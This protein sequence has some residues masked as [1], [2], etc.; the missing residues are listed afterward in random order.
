MLCNATGQNFIQIFR[1]F[2]ITTLRMAHM[3]LLELGPYTS[4]F[5]EELSTSH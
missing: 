5:S 2:R 1:I 3:L 4:I